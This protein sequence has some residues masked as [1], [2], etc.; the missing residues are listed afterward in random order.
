MNE[1]QLEQ[2]DNPVRS[3]GHGIRNRAST[4]A[5]LTVKTAIDVGPGLVGDFFD[6]APLG[7]HGNA[8][9][10][11]C[12]YRFHGHYPISKLPAQI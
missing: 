6:N 9:N 12:I 11:N 10:F 4:A 2:M 8:D 1:P 7:V 5:A 3:V